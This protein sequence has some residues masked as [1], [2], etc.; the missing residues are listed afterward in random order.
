MV[1]GSTGL[2]THPTSTKQL[3]KIARSEWGIVNG[4]P[5][6]RDITRKEGQTHMTNK[7]MGRVLAEI[8]NLVIAF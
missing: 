5:H 2:T 8:T 1:Y 6:H 7:E 3:L 4:L